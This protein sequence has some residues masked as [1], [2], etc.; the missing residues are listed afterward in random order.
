MTLRSLFFWPHLAAGVAAGAVILIMS[1]TGVLLTYEKQ[2]VAWADRGVTASAGGRLALP[3]EELLARVQTATGC[4]ATAL[5]VSADAEAPARLTMGSGTL[6]VDPYSGAVLGESA[7]R[8]RR[9]FRG[10][11]DWHRW[12]AAS[13]ENR[14]AARAVTGWANVIFLFIILSGLYLWMPRRWT[15]QHVRPVALFRTGLSGKARDFNWHNTLGIWCAIPLF[16]IVVSV[17][18]ISFP[19]ANALLFRA[20]GDVPPAPGGAGP[21]AGAPAVPHDPARLLAGMNE[22]LL[23]AANRME[24]WRTITV[25]VPASPDAPLTFTVDGGTGGQPQYRG[26]YVVPRT[27]G[28]VARWEPFSSQSRGRR[29]RSLARFLHTGEVLGLPGQTV[30]GLASL[31]SVV[32]VWTGL[33][34]AWR[35]FFTQKRAARAVVEGDRQAA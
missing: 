15:W 2:M 4:A 23:E 25:R 33:A 35:R 16:F 28:A 21:R 8:L 9:F 11:T 18:P 10:V 34:L 26:T 20:A 13:G 6:L 7:P 19:W 22:G 24:G 5:T 30:A 17:M 32:L 3:A 14:Q 1:V 27:E 31:G 29:V 12:L